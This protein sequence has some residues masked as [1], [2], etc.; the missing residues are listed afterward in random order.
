MRLKRGRQLYFLKT[1]RTRVHSRTGLR[2]PHERRSSRRKE[3]LTFSGRNRMNLLT[4]SATVQGINAETVRR[5]ERA[6]AVVSTFARPGFR[7]SANQQQPECEVP[8]EPE[9]RQDCRCKFL[10]VICCSSIR[11]SPSGVRRSE[12]ERTEPERSRTPEGEGR[13]EE[14]QITERNL[15]RQS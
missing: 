3:A 4:S 6:S 9:R 2:V 7:S 1:Q 15:H 11:P 14:Q 13:M 5:I 12:G 10:S 8:Q